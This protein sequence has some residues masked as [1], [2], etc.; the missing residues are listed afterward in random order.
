MNIPKIYQ[1]KNQ[2][3]LSNADL[4]RILGITPAAVTKVF[5]HGGKFTREHFALLIEASGGKITWE[6]YAPH[7][8]DEPQP[9][10]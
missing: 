9:A 8:Q 5:K 1:W 3:N 2:K 4:A 6:D 7:R 10:L